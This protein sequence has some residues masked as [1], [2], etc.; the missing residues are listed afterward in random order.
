[1]RSTPSIDAGFL[2]RTYRTTLFV[3]G[4]VTLL[5]CATANAKWVLN[6]ALG[7]LI[8]VA[9]VKVT[10]LFVTQTY[11]AP[12]E[13]K[14]KRRWLGWLMVGKWLLLAA[15]LYFLH[16][17]RYFDGVFLLMG[18]ATLHA[19]LILKT[20]GIMLQSSTTRSQQHK[21]PKRHT[22]HDARRGVSD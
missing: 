10:E 1:M 17:L 18:L 4:I 9:F 15:G 22:E 21:Q 8:M 13:P 6:Y 14:P 19:V 11:R 16:R 12:H 5:L 2:Q 20:C 7:V 3:G